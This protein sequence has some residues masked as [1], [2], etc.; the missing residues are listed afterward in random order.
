LEPTVGLNPAVADR[1][2]PRVK[3]T[4]L[5]AGDVAYAAK[6]A[7][8][9]AEARAQKR[10]AEEARRRLDQAWREYEEHQQLQAAAERDVH[11]LFW[12]RAWIREHGGS[13]AAALKKTHPDHGGDSADF[14][15]TM[16]AR[17]IIRRSRQR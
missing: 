4:I 2:G 7:A 14:Q 1:R 10:L 15:F 13:I 9:A 3:P 12:A 6:I 17:D 11:D 8:R 16:K 5:T